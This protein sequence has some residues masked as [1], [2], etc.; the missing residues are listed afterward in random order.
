MNHRAQLDALDAL[1]E[2]GDEQGYLTKDDIEQEIPAISDDSELLSEVGEALKAE[3]ITVV[4]TIIHRNGKR[5]R[6][7]GKPKKTSDHIDLN[8][9]EAGDVPLLS[10][11]EEVALAQLIKMGARNQ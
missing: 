4:D 11:D 9:H 8:L 7:S 2:L 5:S 6:K 3:G 1:V 10:R